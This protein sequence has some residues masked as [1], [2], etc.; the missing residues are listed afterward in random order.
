[1]PLTINLPASIKSK[2]EAIQYLTMLHSTGYD[3]HCEDLVYDGTPEGGILWDK[4]KEECPNVNE[5]VFMDVLMAQ[6]HEYHEDPCQVL[7]RLSGLDGITVQYLIDEL[8]KVEDKT[9]PVTVCL[10]G[11][12]FDVTFVDDSMKDLIE[13][14]LINN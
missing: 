8:M 1:M 13:L 7:C 10:N 4:P 9:L 11:D 14:N 12:R 6:V 5:Q 2:V 3:Y